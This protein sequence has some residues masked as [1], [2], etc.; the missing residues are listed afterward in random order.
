ML[1]FIV[2]VLVSPLAIITDI[3][4]MIISGLLWDAR[5]IQHN[6]DSLKML[7]DKTYREIK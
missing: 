3:L 6:S 4:N 2:L 5:F 1:K 7:W